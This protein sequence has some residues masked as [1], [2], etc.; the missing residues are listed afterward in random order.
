MIA[1]FMSLTLSAIFV[2]WWVESQLPIMIIHEPPKVVYAT[3]KEIA[4]EWYLTRK[5]WCPGKLNLLAMEKQEES[6]RYH[7][8]SLGEYSYAIYQGTMRFIRV[9][10]LKDLPKGEWTLQFNLETYCNPVFANTQKIAVEF[11][12]K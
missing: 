9:Y 10:Q 4:I 11:V 2:Y 8:V 5:Q 7:V 12:L 1:A 3:N 6:N